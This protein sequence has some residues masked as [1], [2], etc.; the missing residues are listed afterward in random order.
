MYIIKYRYII[1][2]VSIF[3]I[4]KVY[5]NCILYA[6]DIYGDSD[7][8]FIFNEYFAA[9]FEI[10]PEN[11][12]LSKNK[13]FIKNMCNISPNV[14]M[15]TLVYDIIGVAN[16]LENKLINISISYKNDPYK[17]IYKF[18]EKP[19]NG[20]ICKKLY[21]NQGK[22]ITNVEIYV[23]NE[24]E[25]LL[26]NYGIFINNKEVKFKFFFDIKDTFNFKDFV[27]KIL[28]VLSIVILICVIIGY[29]FIKIYKNNMFRLY[30]K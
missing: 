18:S 26:N 20:V 13:C 3:L 15:Q 16:V 28:C 14:G 4:V 21:L 11:I 5:T 24:I 29:I 6:Y 22:Y 2:I 30:I 27:Y 19:K 17:T 10:Y 12:I 7:C 8:R 1:T 9:H 25:K 23:N